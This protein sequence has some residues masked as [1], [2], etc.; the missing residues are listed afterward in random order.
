MS[1]RETE[2]L[3]LRHVGEVAAVVARHAESVLD[4]SQ[5]LAS[6]ALQTYWKASRQRA[7][8]WQFSL[9]DALEASK[10]DQPLGK[11]TVR[12]VTSVI[13]EVLSTELVTRLWTC[14]LVGHE[15]KH[16]TNHE[17]LA[18]RVLTDHMT[19]RRSSL[20]LLT[21]PIALPSAE[22]LTLNRIRQRAERWTDCLLATLPRVCVASEFAFDLDRYHEFAEDDDVMSKISSRFSGWHL[23]ALSLRV[24]TS[25]GPQ[26]SQ[27]R[28]ELHR[29]I[30]DSIGAVIDSA[31]NANSTQ[32]QE[33]FDLDKPTNDDDVA[34]IAFDKIADDEDVVDDAKDAAPETV[35]EA[36]TAI[37]DVPHIANEP[38]PE[39]DLLRSDGLAEDVNPDVEAVLAENFGPE[40]IDDA[41][42]QLS[43]EVVG[44]DDS[45]LQADIDFDIQEGTPEH[46]IGNVSP[47]GLLPLEPSDLEAGDLK[48]NDLEADAVD[49]FEAEAE[50]S[51][52]VESTDLVNAEIVGSFFESDGAFTRFPAEDFEAALE[53]SEF[54][55]KLSVTATGLCFRTLYPERG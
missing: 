55:P 27:M 34:P 39:L 3:D 10:R 24:A 36:V 31:T 16:R 23:L 22:I 54:V 17:T 28:N 4:S 44:L 9:D 12:A 15:R 1:S 50:I 38:L 14:V 30:L 8:L 13:A 42:D 33:K 26:T 32:V 11:H 37:D 46:A 21:H 48:P 49:P 7:D 43:E 29:D 40:A 52:V 6:P 5:C 51:K 47:G 18:R 25:G 20:R 19:A 35:D 53:P 41:A 2:S 45:T